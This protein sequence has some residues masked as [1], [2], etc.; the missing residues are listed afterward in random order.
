MCHAPPVVALLAAGNEATPC[1]YARE[2]ANVCGEH[3]AHFKPRIGA[4]NGCLQ[5]D[6]AN[7]GQ[8]ASA[9]EMQS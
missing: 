8:A 4:V 2:F 3:G 1:R 7:S 6:G 9:Q 5:A